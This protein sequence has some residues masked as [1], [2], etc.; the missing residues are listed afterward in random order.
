[1]ERK[2]HNDHSINLKSRRIHIRIW[3]HGVWHI[4]SII[5]REDW[6]GKVT[7]SIM[8]W[9]RWKWII[10]ERLVSI[11]WWRRSWSCWI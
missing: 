3:I 11:A 2:T 10:A 6:I 8:Y 5:G 4:R 7:S 1:M 9:I